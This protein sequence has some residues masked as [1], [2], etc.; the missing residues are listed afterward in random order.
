MKEVH[1]QNLE[2]FIEMVKDT[3]TCMFITMEKNAENISGRPMGI[4]KIDDDGTM[5]FFTKASSYKADEI[6]ESKKVAIAI[7]NESSNN[8]LM[9]HGTATLVNDKEKMAALWG[10]IMK[11]WFPLGLDDP[12]MTLIKVIPTEVNYWDSSS[13]KM[14]VLFNMLKAIVTGKEYADGEHG[15]INL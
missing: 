15:K 8:Y 2:K 12:D 1:N 4:T 3:R 6:E 9:I 5:W 10:S 11:A 14:V 7:T 13:S